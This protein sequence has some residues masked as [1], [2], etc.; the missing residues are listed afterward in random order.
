MTTQSIARKSFVLGAQEGRTEQPLDILG[1]KMLAKLTND[2][3]D[4]TVAIFQQN[5]PPMSGPPLH[6]HSREDEWF[7]VLEGQITIQVDG[8]RT[9]LRAGDSAFA[10]R[11]TVHTYQN[12][13]VV[14]A[15][16]LVMV[17]PGSFQRFFEE[18]SLLNRGLPAPDLVQAEKLMNKYGVELLGPPLS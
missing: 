10:P 11:G 14:P 1:A 9:I 18:L 4:G 17:T 6:R 3:T 16:H 12:F 5:V 15:R 8:Q 13:G 7:Y 2:D